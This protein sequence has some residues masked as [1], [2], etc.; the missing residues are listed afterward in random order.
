MKK[1]RIYLAY[2]EE[3][4]HPAMQVYEL[5]WMYSHHET[6]SRRYSHVVIDD[7]LE[8]AIVMELMVGF[9]QPDLN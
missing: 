6:C 4:Y 7:D 3:C 2:C 5:Q 8:A 1:I 9:I